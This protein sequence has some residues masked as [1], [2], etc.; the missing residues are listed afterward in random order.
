MR[1]LIADD[2]QP[3]RNSLRLLLEAYG[4]T[5][6]EAA[7]IHCARDLLASA[8]PIDLVL[9]DL[10]FKGSPDGLDLLETLSAR[11]DAPP[12]I[13]TSGMGVVSHA[14]KAL[15]L[16]ARDYLIKPIDPDQLRQRLAFLEQEKRPAD[17]P[18]RLD[19]EADCIRFD[20]G[21]CLICQSPP[22]K[23]LLRRVQ[24]VVDQEF[25]LLLQGETG[26]GKGLLARLIHAFSHR[27][28]GPFVA[29][30]CS[31]IP[32][33][34]AEAELF[35]HEKGAFTGAQ[36]KRIGLLQQADGGTLF[37]DE[38]GEL[39]LEMQSKLLTALEEGQI[40]PLG[41]NR[42]I[43]VDFRLL[44]ATNR[45]LAAEVEAGRFRAD[46]YYR[47]STITLSI[48]ALRERPEDIQPLAEMIVGEL[49]RS[50][51]REYVTIP[52]ETLLQLTQYDWP[53]NVR[54]LR[55]TLVRAMAETTGLELKLDAGAL[56]ARNAAPLEKATGAAG[57]PRKALVIDKIL[58]LEEVERRYVQAALARLGGN[59]L[60][61]AKAL[62]I[63]R[64]TLR[65]KLGGS[66]D[67]DE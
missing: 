55:N 13:I 59:K 19:P 28:S 14:I 64:G 39:P 25:P 37:L 9:L 65:R 11:S 18:P 51:H 27:R 24:T 16:G 52:P 63:S 3:L 44:A 36:G 54:E 1:I 45:D 21:H 4:H 41:A 5:V 57:E 66:E 40:R 2:E 15:K 17:S 60:A 61:T 43:E 42:P 48:P 31:A 32:G 30:N 67:A 49:R 58:P 34:L 38:I 35:G 29:V 50:F 23:H 6:I 22:M 10:F 46:L 62:G 47:I 20:Q 7:D 12:V 53:G 56:A 33:D 8:P 26:V